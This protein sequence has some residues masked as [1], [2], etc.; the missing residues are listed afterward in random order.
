MAVLEPNVCRSCDNRNI[1]P[2][3]NSSAAA[4]FSISHAKQPSAF[5]EAAKRNQTGKLREKY[6]TYLKRTLR[7]FHQPAVVIFRAPKKYKHSGSG[8]TGAEGSTQTKS[9]VC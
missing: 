2:Y 7:S 1:V 4:K 6:T 8:S 3:Y 5:A 9:N